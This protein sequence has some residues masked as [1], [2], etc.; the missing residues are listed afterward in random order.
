MTPTPAL[1]LEAPSVIRYHGA[2]EDDFAYWA[3][4]C[5]FPPAWLRALTEDAVFYRCQE[6]FFDRPSSIGNG[7][8]PNVY[9]V[10]LTH[11]VTVYF[12]IEKGDAMIRGYCWD[13]GRPVEE[14]DDAGGFYCEYDW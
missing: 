14:D 3:E 13:L 11:R 5:G 6:A 12:T 10:P 1:I 9:C 4:G 2:L 7:K 8:R